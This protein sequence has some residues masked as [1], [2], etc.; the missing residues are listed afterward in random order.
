MSPE[1]KKRIVQIVGQALI[2]DGVLADA[3]RAHLEGVME[4]LGMSD[5]ERKEAFRGISVDS[6]VEERVAELS[7][8]GRAR[9]RAEV[10]AVASTSGDSGRAERE[11]VAHL[12]GLLAS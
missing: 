2:A 4:G 11:I 3:E 6:P 5:A 1:D 7:A 9:L 8:E 10:D 12:R